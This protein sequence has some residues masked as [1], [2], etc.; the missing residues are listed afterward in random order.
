MPR[1]P[2]YDQNTRTPEFGTGGLGQFGQSTQAMAG[3]GGA[4][5]ANARGAQGQALGMYQDMAAGNG[6]SVA[7]LQMQQG[8]DQ[9]IANQMAMQAQGRG[10]NLGANMRA[11]SQAGVGMQM[12]GNQQAAQLRAQEQ[13]AAMAGA[14][15]LSTEM[16]GQGLQQQLGAQGMLGD[17]YGQ[18]LAAQT[19]WGLGQRELDLK[20]RQGNRQFG[21]DLGF[22]I[23][24]RIFSDM[25]AKQEIVPTTT[26]GLG[27]LHPL[28]LQTDPYGMRVGA[29]DPRLYV[30]DVPPLEARSSLAPVSPAAEPA[31]GAMSAEARDA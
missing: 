28:A 14:A 4:A 5:L 20:Q 29:D 1:L 11:A 19:Q 3:S 23:T 7:Q 13:Q 30:T 26:P 18:Q 8:Q 15:G 17:A 2:Y 21:M 24:D 6:P 25:R 27:G 16:A 31:P 10:G 12:Q 9:A 22:G